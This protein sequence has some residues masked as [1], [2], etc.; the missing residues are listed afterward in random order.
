ML[1]FA[2]TILWNGEY[3]QLGT[4]NG[5]QY[6]LKTHVVTQ[7]INLIGLVRLW[8]PFEINFFT[9]PQSKQNIFRQNVFKS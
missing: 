8:N 6:Q 1:T 7:V 4:S 9:E 5:N 3:H 2:I